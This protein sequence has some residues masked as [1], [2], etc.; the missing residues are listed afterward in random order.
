M[1]INSLAIMNFKG[2][3]SFQLE[4]NGKNANI[5][6]DNGTGKTTIYD[7]WLWLLFGKN[8]NDRKDFEVRPL[9]TDGNPINGLIT[10][11]DASLDIDGKTIALRKTT[12]EKRGTPKGL[13]SEVFLGMQSEY[14]INMVKVRKTDYDNFIKSITDEKLFKILANPI[15]FN[16]MITWSERRKILMD[17]TL[18]LNDSEIAKLDE[19]LSPV[20]PLLENM[21]AENL[22]KELERRKKTLEQ[23][24]LSIPVRIDEIKKTMERLKVNEPIDNLKQKLEALRKQKQEI[25]SSIKNPNAEKLM[26]LS[27]KVAQIQAERQSRINELKKG[28]RSI[29]EIE[30]EAEALKDKLSFLEK[31]IEQKRK[32]WLEIKKEK[33]EIS[34]KC[35]CC[36][37]KL[38]EDKIK[39]AF[40][41]F[42]LKKAEKM[43]VVESEGKAYRVEYEN[44]NKKM[45]ALKN[46][47]IKTGEIE[48]KIKSIISEPIPEEIEIQ[49]IKKQMDDQNLKID[50]STIDVEI[51]QIEKKIAL[52]NSSKE[53]NDRIRDLMEQEKAVKLE[54]ADLTD[55]IDM[56]DGVTTKKIELMEQNINE[57]FEFVRFKLFKEKTK[58]TYEETCESTVDGVPYNNL[59]HGAKIY[60]GLD[61][62]RTLSD[63]YGVSI[64][65]FID[66]RESVTTIPDMGDIQIINL[67]VQKGSNL[68]IDVG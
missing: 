26:A 40:E 52:T 23:E 6:G 64:P 65:I 10:S 29:E 19:S 27:N 57:K 45:S 8:S 62:I 49:N 5:Y 60:A 1:K 47:I 30:M 24:A 43:E 7:A 28:I 20:A 37:A 3:K 55:T 2:I 56:L 51:E 36:G 59:N 53:M 68:K 66:N 42:N 34:D 35:P 61:I 13:N 39:K 22:K 48:K 21:S 67:I 44:L 41:E 14:F 31:K 25:T 16:E 63:K 4:L 46:E 15:Y 33:P 18:D 54:I 17:F 9:D 58:G 50:T 11:V 12:K 32:E 38:S